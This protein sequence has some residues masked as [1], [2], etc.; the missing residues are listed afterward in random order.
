VHQL[1][2][3]ERE[4][5]SRVLRGFLNKEIAFEL[6]IA[7]RT[8]KIHRAHLMTKLNVGSVAELARLVERS[9]ALPEIQ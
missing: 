9:G 8:V 3:R 1:S 5:C 4:V 7:E 6:G 2:I